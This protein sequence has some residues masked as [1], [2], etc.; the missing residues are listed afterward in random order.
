MSEGA[1]ADGNWR[2]GQENAFTVAFSTGLGR[3]DRIIGKDYIRKIEYWASAPAASGLEQERDDEAALRGAGPRRRFRKGRGAADGGEH[4]FI[5]LGLSARSQDFRRADGARLRQR[6]AD[7]DRA[8]GGG[9]ARLELGE[10]LADLLPVGLDRIAG[11]AGLFLAF[12]SP[13]AVALV[14][15]PVWASSAALATAGRRLGNGMSGAS[16]PGADRAATSG[17]G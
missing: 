1:G 12:S 11:L 3:V 16:T 15:P 9:A 7:D 14:V 4:A 17:S 10:T 13:V 2:R 8:G 5:E 6:E